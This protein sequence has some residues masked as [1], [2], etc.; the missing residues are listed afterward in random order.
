MFKLKSI[1]FIHDEQ[2]QEYEFTEHSFVYGENT[3]GK[4][5]LTMV[6][7]YI[8]GSSGKLTYRGLDHIDSIEAHL[9]NDM[10][11]LWIKRDIQGNCFYKRTE[12]SDFIEVSLDIYKDNICLMLVSKPNNRYLDIYRK[13]FDERPTF[14]SFNFLNYIEE[15]GVGDL[16]IVFTKTK[17]IK[18]NIRVRNIM[19]FFFNFEKIE[20][21]YEKELLLEQ[22]SGELDKITRDYQEYQRIQIQ[23]RNIFKELQLPYTGKYQM[24]YK[25]FCDFK[26]TY[27]RKAK[28]KEKDLVYLSQAAFALSEEIKLYQFM[29][30]QSS[31]MI[32]RK[33]RIKRLLSILDAVV[34]DT[35]E[36]AEY[37]QF[38]KNTIQR[39]DDENV[40]LSLTDYNRVIKDIKKEKGHLDDEIALLKGKAVEIS[41]EDAVKKVGL[42]EHLFYV[43]R[44]NIDVGKMETLQK[45]VD[46]LKKEIKELKL[47]FDQN[48]VNTFNE[49]LT[50]V[51]LREGLAIKHLDED[52]KEDCFSLEYDPFRVCLYAKHREG[53]KIVKFMPGSMARQ[54]HIQ[55]LLYLTMFEYLIENF[56][57]F[58]YM[59]LLVVDS[60]NQ[61]MEINCFNKI[62]PVIM[63]MV[64]KIGIQTIFISKDKI[65]GIRSEDFIDISEGLNRFHQS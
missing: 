41:Y 9:T 38:I 40:I 58:I 30:N 57:D 52:L 36:Y 59:P 53:D 19:N 15:K 11:N 13:V 51:Y 1:K 65:D 20:Q 7:D 61:S 27:T 46:E 6:I 56:P 8:L 10:T 32:E 4:T 26:N 49:R 64:E 22:S 24:D 33:E 55:I 29:K 54:T 16:S 25:S 14:R 44:E 43:L 63:E 31:N 42:L 60:A 50:K 23:Q 47:S 34:D 5:A 12:E 28:E 37:T 62:Y 3:K 2:T 21:I 39:I 18:H 35:P 17:D 48:K 45:K